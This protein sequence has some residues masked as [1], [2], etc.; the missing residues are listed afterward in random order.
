MLRL[1]WVATLALLLVGVVGTSPG[2]AQSS[3]G[4]ETAEE[5]AKRAASIAD[6]ARRQRE[7]A[8]GAQG[9]T[10]PAESPAPTSGDGTGLSVGV[11]L[12][13]ATPVNN[14]S[15]EGAEVSRL[16]FVLRYM[17]LQNFGLEAAAGPGLWWTEAVSPFH[18]AARLGA[19]VKGDTFTIGAGAGF[20]LY[21]NPNDRPPHYG[22]AELYLAPGVQVDQFVASLK[23]GY[24]FWSEL[25]RLNGTPGLG[26]NVGWM[27]N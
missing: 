16:E 6:E 14:D 23:V 24:V 5:V 12:N 9:V 19:L 20:G 18:A 1:L 17:L 25:E 2:F 10:S 7:A 13:L 3:G 8:A 22:A 4:D 27:F 15:D 21:Q 11:A 26:L